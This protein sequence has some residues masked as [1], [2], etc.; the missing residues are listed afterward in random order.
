FVLLENCRGVYSRR[1]PSPAKMAAT[2]RVAGRPRQSAPPPNLAQLSLFP[3]LP[4]AIDIQPA[5]RLTETNVARTLPPQRRGA[6]FP[7]TVSADGRVAERVG[8]DDVDLR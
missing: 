1:A 4:P 3:G 7:T 2:M 5:I 6:L 8:R